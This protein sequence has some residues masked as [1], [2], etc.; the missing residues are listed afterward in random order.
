MV[1][2]IS[3]NVDEV[4]ELDY[5]VEESSDSVVN[6]K[7][8][9]NGKS[10]YYISTDTYVFKPNDTGIYKFELN[11]QVFEVEVFDIP[12]TV[13]DDFEDQ[14]MSE[15]TNGSG[16]EFISG[17]NGSYAVSSPFGGSNTTDVYSLPGD[18]LPYY[19]EKGSHI[20]FYGKGRN[21]ESNQGWGFYW[22]LSDLSNHY[23]I[24]ADAD[25]NEMRIG[26]VDSGSQSLNSVNQSIET[27][28][29]YRNDILWKTDGSNEKLWELYD[30]N[31][32]LLNSITLTDSRFDQNRGIGLS[33]GP[34]GAAYDYIQVLGS[35]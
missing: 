23:K 24:D 1:S 30:E 35:V 6:F 16:W 22:G 28:T 34:T 27:G 32:N 26:Y 18:G 3:M 19:P 20:R 5:R 2:E 9:P 29:W 25:A 17:F 21:I 7:K 11:G 13:L 15:Y 31:D 8:N 14:N 10:D 4:L 12:N 33:S